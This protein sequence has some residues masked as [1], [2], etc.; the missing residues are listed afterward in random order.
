MK[1]NNI[2][3]EGVRLTMISESFIARPYLC[4]AG[5][6]TQGYGTTRN[7]DTGRRIQKSDG[8]ITIET[9]KRWLEIDYRDVYFPVT[10]RLVTDAVLQHEMDALCDFTYNTGGFWMNKRT[11]GRHPY[12]LF[13]LVNQ[14]KAGKVKKIDLEKYWL[15]CAITGGGKVLPGLITRRKREVELFFTGKFV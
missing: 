14:F 2:G 1:I 7:P 13:S 9:A 15:D 3:A 8:I 10:D 6:W 5:V 4:P 11:G 12:R